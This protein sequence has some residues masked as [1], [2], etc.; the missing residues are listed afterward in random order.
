MLSG[1]AGSC[2][3][4][5]VAAASAAVPAALNGFPVFPGA[6]HA[7]D[8]QPH[9]QDQNCKYYYCSHSQT[10]LNFSFIL[11]RLRRKVHLFADY[12]ATLLT[13]TFNVPLSL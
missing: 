8:D 11:A 6:D 4:V 2:A 9:D 13:L 12:L 1:V 3:A 7:P 5:T 10:S